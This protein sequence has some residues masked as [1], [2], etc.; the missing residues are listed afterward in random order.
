[1]LKNMCKERQSYHNNT[2]KTKVER[3]KKITLLTIRER[4]EG[5]SCRSLH[6]RSNK[7]NTFS[8]F[9]NSFGIY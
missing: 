5:M 6:L 8:S 4:L 3:E 7:F 1:M 2:S 9:P